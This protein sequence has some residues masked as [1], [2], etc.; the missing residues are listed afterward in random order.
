MSAQDPI[1]RRQFL[2]KS[3]L[4]AAAATAVAAPRPAGAQINNSA[5]LSTRPVRLGFIGAGIRGTLLME[6]AAGIA[7]VQLSA[8]ADCYKGH[9]DRAVESFSPAPAVTGNYTEILAQPDIDAVA[10]AAPD[11]WHLKMTQ[12]AL[13][14]GKHVYIEKPMTHSWEEGE[15]F[16]A[17]VERS[18]RIVQ[19]GSQY[20]SMGCARRAAEFIRS[21]RLGL[22]TLVEG[23]IHRNSATGAWYYPIPPDAS[24]ATVDFKRFLGAAPPHEFDLRRF[25]QWRLFWDYSG[26]LPTD[27]F[28][29][30]ITATHQLM[31]VQE[32]ES[33]FAFADTYHWKNYREVP[34]QMT[35]MVKYPEGFV[36]RLTAT[37]G[38]SHPG[39]ILTFYGSAGTMEYNGDS[40]KFYD[41]PRSDSFGYSTHSWPKATTA[42]FKEVMGLNDRLAAMDG[43]ETADPVEYKSPN[44]E[45][46][47]RAHMRNWIEAIRTGGKPIE[48]VRFGHHAALV[49]HMCNLSYKA[50]KPVRWNRTTRRV[51][52]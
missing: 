38:N 47:T 24:P 46:S 49:G 22:V 36:L 45:D 50:G 11:H 14:A 19:A 20:M 12:D 28:V 51:E 6:A 13:A 3:T 31:G 33:V 17:A 9:L 1:S 39:P 42:R 35:S 18:G 41:E 37:A 25:F 21:G 44:D 29:H 4:A 40:F 48:D 10:I 30:L 52:S 34:D 7:G 8:V 2:Q 43:P 16:I 5:G 27:L 32:P 15:A 26:G 23:K